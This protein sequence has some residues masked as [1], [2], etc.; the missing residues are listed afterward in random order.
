M[1]QP[2]AFLS[3]VDWSL[4][5][6]A[7]GMGALVSLLETVRSRNAQRGKQLPL[8]PWGTV[9]PESLVSALVGT[10]GTLV[11]TGLV[12]PLRT[13]EGV[14]LVAAV[15]AVIVP[16][17]WEFLRNNGWEVAVDWAA[18][19]ATGPLQK[20]AEKAAA[21]TKKGGPPDDPQGTESEGDERE[22]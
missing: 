1:T 14:G 17:A 9:L 10:L 5:A 12:K 11:I 20:L 13:F 19:S 16:R 8:S 3:A 2:A 4:V 22:P 6:Y 21:R 18:A 7:A 15:L